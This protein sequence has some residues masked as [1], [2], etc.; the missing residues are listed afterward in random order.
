VWGSGCIDPHFL[1]LG[2]SWRWAV[3]FT[4]RPLYPRERA[5]DTPW[6]EEV[7][8]TSEP[9]WTTWKKFLTLPELEF[10]PLD[11]PAR[12]QSLCRLSY[13][14]SCL[15]YVPE[16]KFHTHPL[17]YTLHCWIHRRSH[18]SVCPSIRPVAI[19]EVTDVFYAV[20]AGC[21]PVS[22]AAR[23]TARSYCPADSANLPNYVTASRLE[24]FGTP[25]TWYSSS[26][27]ISDFS[28]VKTTYER[29]FI[30][31]NGAISQLIWETYQLMSRQSINK[32]TGSWILARNSCKI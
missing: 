8:W 16:T 29:V 6:M 20:S 7:G 10:L 2:T 9:V 3:S 4:L 22:E 27:I 11:R 31:T 32:W 19:T 23:F 1:D 24:T 25:E 5:P 17:S 18:T 14:G 15:V 21:C 28:K 26:C 13:P 12:S 30:I